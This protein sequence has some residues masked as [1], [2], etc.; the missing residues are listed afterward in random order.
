MTLCEYHVN[1]GKYRETVLLL[2]KQV[3]DRLHELKSS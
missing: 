1:H 3:E 2:T